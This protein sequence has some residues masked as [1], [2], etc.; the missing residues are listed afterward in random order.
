MRTCSPPPASARRCGHC[1]VSLP[2]PVSVCR[3]VSV[4]VTRTCS[5]PLSASA[6]SS[7]RLSTWNCCVSSWWSSQSCD[8]ASAPPARR[9]TAPHA[10]SARRSR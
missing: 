3:C 10:A 1:S 6:A 2:V 8:C 9:A 5:R 4:H 7:R